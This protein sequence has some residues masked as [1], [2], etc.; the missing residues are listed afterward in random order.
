MI[1]R[2]KGTAITQRKKL[3]LRR[4][5]NNITRKVPP[6]RVAVS[7]AASVCPTLLID[8]SNIVIVM[9]TLTT[10]VLSQSR[11]NRS[12]SGGASSYASK[13][14]ANSQFLLSCHVVNGSWTH[15]SNS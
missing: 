6:K 13:Y 11:S 15:K 10:R 4:V 9:N 2:L 1:V 5:H 12:I 3:L 7:S 14:V 8:Q